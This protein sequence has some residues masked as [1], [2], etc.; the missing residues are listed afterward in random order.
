M[1]TFSKT[2]AL[3]LMVATCAVAAD[4]RKLGFVPFR[5]LAA[6]LVP[7]RQLARTKQSA[8]KSAP[9]IPIRQLVA[10]LIPIR[11]LARTKQT[12]RKSAPR[13]PIRQLARTKARSLKSWWCKSWVTEDKC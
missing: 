9:R 2:L 7:F 13:I 6:P 10:P 1:N 12:A 3:A 5:Q 8:G 4:A 11:Q